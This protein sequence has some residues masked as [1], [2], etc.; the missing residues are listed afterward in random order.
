[1]RNGLQKTHRAAEEDAD[2]AVENLK[3]PV[4]TFGK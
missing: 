3:T 4:T 1:M 2:K